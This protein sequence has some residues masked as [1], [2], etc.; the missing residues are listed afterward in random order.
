M[1]EKTKPTEYLKP[2][3]Q[4]VLADELTSISLK[5]LE[6]LF[7]GIALSW[8]IYFDKKA[9]LKAS[10]HNENHIIPVIEANQILLENVEIG[11]DPLKGIPNVLSQASC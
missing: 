5:G 3:D 11:N 7:L 8:H 4:I 6:Q 9:G 2:P 1:V 10:A